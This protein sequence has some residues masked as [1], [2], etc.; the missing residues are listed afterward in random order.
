MVIKLMARDV[1]DDGPDFREYA[2][3]CFIV[4]LVW[5][6]GVLL[7]LV[8]S[9]LAIKIFIV[10]FMGVLCLA[11]SCFEFFLSIRVHMEEEGGGEV[12]NLTAQG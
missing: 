7:G 3:G 8:C 5:T 4:F 2:L 10:V 6:I 12:V 9:S 11:L 1:I